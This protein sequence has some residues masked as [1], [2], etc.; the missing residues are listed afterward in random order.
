MSLLENKNLKHFYINEE[1]SFY[2]LSHQD[3]RKLKDWLNLCETQLSRLGYH[4]IEMVGN[5]AYGFVFAGSDHSGKQYVFKFA[6][7]TLPQHIQDR[8]EDEGFMLSALK[9]PGIPQFIEFQNLS[10]QSILM[11]ERAAGITLEQLSH[12]RGRLVPRLILSIAGQ[13][14]TI[15]LYL[16]QQADM[17]SSRLVVHGDIKPSNIMFDRDTETVSLIDWGAAVHAQLNIGGER[18]NGLGLGA[19]DSNFSTTNAKL[20]DIYFIGDEQLQGDLSSPRFDEQ[21]L[22]GTLYALASGQGSRFGKDAITPES[23]GLPVEF[24][25][26]IAA[27]LAGDS[28]IRRRAGDYFLDNMQYMKR[29]V[30]GNRQND[31]AIRAPLIPFVLSDS[32]EL[33]DSVV[34]SSRKGFLRQAIGAEKFDAQVYRDS[35]AGDYSYYKN[36]LIGMGDTEKAFI[37]AVSHLGHYPVVGGLAINWDQ[38]GVSI[39]S[40]LN[41]Y[42]AHLA[43]ALVSAIN[44][45]VHLGR[46]IN[47]KG[48]FKS[49]MFDARKTLHISRETVNDCFIATPGMQIPFDCSDA[50]LPEDETRLHSYFEDGSDPDEMLELPNSIMQLLTSM[51]QIQHTGCIIFEAVEKDLKIHNYLTLLDTAKVDQFR[52]CLEGILDNIQFIEGLGVSGFMKLPYKNTKFFTHL[53]HQPIHYLAKH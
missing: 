43:P 25:K 46:A 13:M 8:L 37:I 24:A 2:L 21:G 12:Q 40:S 52:Q 50:P 5:G 44:N 11:M 14:A 20:G 3:A 42:N 19:I 23:L 7:M 39:D 28:E 35:N 38:D 26:T 22:A 6:R 10:G 16:R 47:H 53:S 18:I 34:Y 32:N 9:H 31:A 4:D 33:L 51:N 49:C 29:I 27:M 36:Y 17:P 30:S 41:L 1:Q 45:M 15:L 48:V